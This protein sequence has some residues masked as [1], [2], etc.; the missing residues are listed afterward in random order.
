VVEFLGL[1]Q[2]LALGLA[3]L[4]QDPRRVRFA[5]E[6]WKKPS[7]SKPDLIGALAR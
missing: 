2:A 7:G 6:L 5:E 4:A 1:A 3:L